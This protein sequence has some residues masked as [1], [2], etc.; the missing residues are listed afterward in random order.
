MQ[1]ALHWIGLIMK[2]KSDSIHV[3]YKKK[4]SNPIKTFAILI[5]F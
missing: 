4:R 3:V 2:I 5:G 1:F